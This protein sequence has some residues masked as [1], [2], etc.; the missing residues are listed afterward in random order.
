[1]VA[2]AIPLT[3]ALVFVI[4]K[5]FGETINRI[6]LFALILSLGLLVDNATVVIEN[7]HRHCS[8]GKEKKDAIVEAVN[9]VGMGLFISTLTSVIVF[10]P[11]SQI[12]GMMGEYMGPLSFFVPMAFDPVALG[13]VYF[14]SIFGRS[15]FEGQYQLR[16]EAQ[17]G[18]FGPPLCV[19]WK[20]ASKT[21]WG[22]K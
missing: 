21:C 22:R 13:R 16:D 15:L 17:T 5:L 4:G 18:R 7:I 14:V 9:E 12:T 8:L 2:I 6:S 3:I 19:V 20:L 1:M 10:L 11:T